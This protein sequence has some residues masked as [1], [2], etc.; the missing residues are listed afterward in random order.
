MT[1]TEIDKLTPEEINER[2]AK[3]LGWKECQCAPEHRETHKSYMPSKHTRPDYSRSIE[4]VWEVISLP[5]YFWTISNMTHMWF[6]RYTQE[7]GKVLSAS[8]ADTAP[9]AICRAFLRI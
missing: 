5:G 4:A 8:Y 2:V 1:P 9:M 7:G 6:A 3:R